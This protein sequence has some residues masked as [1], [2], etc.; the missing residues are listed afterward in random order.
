MF[1]S[2][3]FPVQGRTVGLTGGSR[4]MGLVAARQLAEKGAHVVI[5]ARDQQT[6]I[7]GLEYIRSGASHPTSQRFLQ[8]SADLTS[9][10]EAAR[11]IKEVVAWNSGP[12]DIVWCCAG[13]AHPTLFIDTPASELHNQMQSNYF[14]S[15]Y[16]AHAAMNCWLRKPAAG[17][18]PAHPAP[19]HLI[20]TSSLVAF[21]SFAGYAS[22]APAKAALRALS[23]TLS[24]E[25]SLYVGVNPDEPPVRLH[26]IFPGTILSEA[27]EVEN[28]VKT[29]LTKLFEEGDVG[30]TPEV[31]V[32]KSI[33]ALEGG[34]EFIT[35]DLNTALLRYSMI[36]GNRRG[37]VRVLS[38]WFLAGVLA[39]VM[40]F[41]RGD[42]DRKATKWGR[43]FGTAI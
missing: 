29:D 22:Y 39:I 4:G 35:T 7:E 17:A 42:M 19:R 13:T 41:I 40:V 20:F 26:T 30:Q 32:R 21:Y 1:S 27:L 33:R 37:W 15:A 8:I 14:T 16:M 31:I 23:D 25:M 11:V 36:G 43:A 24:Q 12:P 38:N 34:E 6:L 2:N 18:R 10:S 9:S 5:V 28:A 3:A